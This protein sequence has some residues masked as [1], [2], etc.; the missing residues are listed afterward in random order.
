LVPCS[1]HADEPIKEVV[2]AARLTPEFTFKITGRSDA[3]AAKRLQALAPDNVV[4]TGYV[5]TE[6]FNELLLAARVVLGLTKLEGIQL[7]AANEGIGA[8]KATVLSDT[9]ILR[10]LFGQ[11]ALFSSNDA[12]S[13]A[14]T[15]REAAERHEALE[16]ASRAL[17]EARAVRWR[18][19]AR[20]AFARGNLPIALP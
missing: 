2:E 6:E 14:K 18:E 13:L 7:S 15:V 9:A 11:A 19:Q 10:E 5:S 1:F 3:S 17:K 16:A 8:G 4:F 12:A 20:L